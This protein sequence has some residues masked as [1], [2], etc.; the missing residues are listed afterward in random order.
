MWEQIWKGVGSV[1]LRRGKE[2]YVWKFYEMLLPG[3]DFRGKKVLEFGC[4]TGINSILMAL[5]GAEVTLL[6]S[7]RKALGIAERNLEALG[8]KGKLVC[9]DVFDSDFDGEFDLTQSEGLVEHFTGRKRQE[10]IDIHA[11]ATKKGGKVLIIVPHR[12]CPPYR[13]GKFMA[14]KTGTWIYHNEHPYS[15][16]ELAQRMGRAGLR[17]GRVLGGELM[18]SMVFLLSPLVLGSSRLIRKG[19]GLPANN[20]LVRL[21]Y[22][23]WFADRWGRIIGAVGDKL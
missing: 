1:D 20:K 2:P 12:R 6:D 3:Y 11:K 18:F 15:K 21:N 19:I 5:R 8:L 16:A 13:A 4:G 17:P 23:N 22:G 14:E 9:Q 7:S 10:I